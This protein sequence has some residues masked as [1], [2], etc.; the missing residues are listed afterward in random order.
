MLITGIIS[1]GETK[2][3]RERCSY[4]R[5]LSSSGTSVDLVFLRNGSVVGDAI[6]ISPGYS[7]KWDNPIDSVR[8]TAQ[9]T[10]TIKF[11]MRIGSEVNYDVPPG[12]TLV[13]PSTQ[14]PYTQTAPA[15]ALTSTSILAANTGRKKIEIQNNDP[16]TTIWV[17]FA[18]VAAVAAPPSVKIGPGGSYTEADYPP[19]GQIFAIAVTTA[20]PLI[21]V[22]EG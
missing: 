8:I 17:N 15:I 12:G 11:V 7:E 1:A 19:T 16:S 3:F 4:F 10:Q 9:A 13:F 6:G 5:I 14:G 20:N 22:I 2:E 21:T 18:G